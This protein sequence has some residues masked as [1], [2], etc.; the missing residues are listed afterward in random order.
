LKLIQVY[1]A[2]VQ[3]DIAGAMYA[4]LK[5]FKIQM[6]HNYVGGGAG[7]LTSNLDV[8]TSYAALGLMDK[9]GKAGGLLGGVFPTK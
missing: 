3:R 9:A 1:L 2:E 4:N 8:I 6:P 7:G 5:D